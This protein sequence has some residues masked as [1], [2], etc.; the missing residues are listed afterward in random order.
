MGTYTR[1]Q[2]ILEDMERNSRLWPLTRYMNSYRKCNPVVHSEVEVFEHFYKHKLK[3]LDSDRY[4]YSSKPACFACPLYFE[5]H[6]ATMVI[7][8]SHEKVY[9]SWGPPTIT[10]FRKG[11][12]A[13]N[14]QQDLMIKI[15]L[16]ARN[17]A[18]G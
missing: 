7:T 18:L 5:H 16:A 11:D 6:P 15:T 14:R 8:E 2:K 17:E 3:F 10:D 9:L 12:L 4:V 13:S 1:T